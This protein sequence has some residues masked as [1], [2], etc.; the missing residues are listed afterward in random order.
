MGHHVTG[1]SEL[2]A[3]RTWVIRNPVANTLASRVVLWWQVEIHRP[4]SWPIRSPSQGSARC[5][6]TG[7]PVAGSN[8]EGPTGDN[9]S[10]RECDARRRAGRGPGSAKCTPSIDFDAT[11]STCVRSNLAATSV[12]RGTEAATRGFDATSSGRGIQAR[13]FK[14]TYAPRTVRL[15]SPTT[16]HASPDR[17]SWS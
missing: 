16:T 15:T 13:Y 3:C 7:F 9:R 1:L 11:A 8:R 5:G 6:R 17:P 2:L 12:E 14:R 10:E 4:P